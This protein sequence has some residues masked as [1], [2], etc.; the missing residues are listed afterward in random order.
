MTKFF[1]KFKKPCFW[2]IFWSFSQFWGQKKFPE[3]LPLPCL[4]L[5]RL[6]A[7]CQNLEDNDM[8]PRKCQQRQKDGWKYGWKDGQTIFYM[9][10]PAT[11][12]GLMNIHQ[13]SYK[14]GSPNRCNSSNAMFL[15][16]D[17]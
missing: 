9:T 8:I 6:L 11:T 1:N 3:N 2:P 7:P 16:K 17:Y 13:K 5:Y 4:M 15:L 10:L 12:W 14:N